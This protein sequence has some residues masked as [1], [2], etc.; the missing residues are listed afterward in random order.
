MIRVSETNLLLAA[1]AVGI[2]G[3]G[4]PRTLDSLMQLQAGG[5]EDLANADTFQD[6]AARNIDAARL[7]RIDARFHDPAASIRA[8]TIEYALAATGGDADHAQIDA[9]ITDLE[10]GLARAPADPK[11]WMM[12]ARARAQLGDRG[13][14]RLALR[15]SIAIAPHDPALALARA[16]FGLQLLSDL[17]PE[18]RQLVSEQIRLAAADQFA[19]L[20]RYVQNGGDPTPIT[21][22]L[23]GDHDKV[24]A[25]LAAISPAAK[26]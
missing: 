14:A 16:E 2:L 22:A 7:E 4:V 10:S 5:T 6:I 3:L 20:V 18:E 19:G 24:A 17:Q 8:G 26:N 9:A 25:L 23:A 11:G 13:G 12:L 21:S 1:L 15:N